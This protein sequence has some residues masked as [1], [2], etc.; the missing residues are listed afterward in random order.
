MRKIIMFSLVLLSA[1]FSYGFRYMNDQSITIKS[2]LTGD[3]CTSIDYNILNNGVGNCNLGGDIRT[4]GIH[5]V[6]VQVEGFERVDIV[7]NDV[8][9]YP[10]LFTILG[11]FLPKNSMFTQ[12]WATVKWFWPLTFSL[13]VNQGKLDISSTITKYRA[14]S[15]FRSCESIELKPIKDQQVQKPESECMIT[16]SINGR[17]VVVEPKTM[18]QIYSLSALDPCAILVRSLFL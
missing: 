2:I 10:H 15:L 5:N 8:C 13:K 9:F 1:S 12:R 7:K 6:W 14:L 4:Y 11:Y 3:F 18:V 17:A 16:F